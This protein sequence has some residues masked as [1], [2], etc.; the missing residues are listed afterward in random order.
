[1]QMRPSRVLRKLRAGGVASCFKLNLID[2]RSAEI[3]AMHGFDCIWAD[4]E[5]T[6]NDLAV[7]ETQVYAAK[8][9]DADLLVRVC[10]RGYNDYL[11][12][13]EMD[14]TGIMVPHCMSAADAREVVRM[15][16]FHPIGRRAYDSGNADGKYCNIPAA[17]YVEQAN[18]E[19]FLILQIEDPEPLA[20]LDEI[21]ATPG[22]DMLFF[23]PGDFSHSLGLPGQFAHPRVIEAR[24]LVAEACARH[25]KWAATPGNP[26]N[27]D[28]LLELGYRFIPMGADVVGLS[29]Y[30]RDMFAQFTQRGL[31]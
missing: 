9:Y 28:E 29:N 1:M 2:A 6:P 23:G 20:E 10:R 18:R 22:V 25:G 12:P 3:A 30:C 26:A 31:A 14:A 21:A 19:R 24:R 7:V 4:M 11:L 16:R 5:H 13:L 27:L 15:S 8:A 17:E